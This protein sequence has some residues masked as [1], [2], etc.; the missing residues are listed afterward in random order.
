[1]IRKTSLSKTMKK[2]V[3]KVSYLRHYLYNMHFFK[4]VTQTRETL[5]GCQYAVIN[6][7]FYLHTPL[8][9]STLLRKTLE[10]SMTSHCSRQQIKFNFTSMKPAGIVIILV[11]AYQL[12][13]P[14][15]VNRSLLSRETLLVEKQAFLILLLC[16]NSSAQKKKL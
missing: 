6:Y 15:E 16:I 11:T 3:T 8:M 14:A 9:N 13:I 2:L 10:L 12:S 4:F 1:M 5:R 7:L